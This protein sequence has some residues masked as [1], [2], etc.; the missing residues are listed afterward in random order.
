MAADVVTL[1]IE[2]NRK[3]DIPD[4][5]LPIAFSS[6]HSRPLKAVDDL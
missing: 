5:I 1:N 6:A 4:G 3:S 2:A